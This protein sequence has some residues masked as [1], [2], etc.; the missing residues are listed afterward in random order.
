MIQLRKDTDLAFFLLR[1]FLKQ[2]K[3]F[4]TSAKSL[5]ESLNL[6]YPTVSKILKVLNKNSVL[7]SVQGSKG[8]YGLGAVYEEF[9]VGQLI[10]M[11]EGPI[12]LTACTSSTEQNC[13]SQAFCGV[14]PHM[15]LMNRVIRDALMA[16]PL[17]YLVNK[18]QRYPKKQEVTAFWKQYF[19]EG[20]RV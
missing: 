3:G 12:A 16:L 14:H 17:S 1:H 4:Q 19:D 20:N 6:P 18:P 13:V 10:E 15:E 9:S 7:E 11:I 8:G 2:P 5:S